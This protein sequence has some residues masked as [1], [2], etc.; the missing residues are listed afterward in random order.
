[1]SATHPD[2]KPLPL[3]T[4]VYVYGNYNSPFTIDEV[5]A[6]LE[7]EH[8]HERQFKIKNLETYV[9]AYCGVDI[10][11]PITDEDGNFKFTVTEYGKELTK[12]F[13]LNKSKKSTERA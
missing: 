7:E 10:F 13:P 3:K 5:V 8:G 4:D 11:S 12:F 1:M 6:A 9:L 2:F